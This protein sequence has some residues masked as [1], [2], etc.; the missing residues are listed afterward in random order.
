MK[1]LLFA[2]PKGR[3]LDEL[4]PLLKKI[5]II[6]EDDFFNDNSRKLVFKTN[7]ENLEIVK[8][9][10]F[11]VATFVKFGAADLGICGLDVLEEFSKENTAEKNYVSEIFPLI[12]LK[13]GKCRL[14]IAAKKSVA[15]D[16]KSRSHIR[17]ATKYTAIAQKYFSALGIQAEAV[18][19]NGS[20]EIAPQLNLCDFILDLVSSGKTL[21]ENDMVELE[22]ILDVTSYLIVNRTSFKTANQEINELISIF[23]GA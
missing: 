18:K 16:L 2:V 12:D 22:K 6:P 10:S 5:G 17:I 3:I 15:L 7:R 23:D 21:I 14:S 1:K 9:R 20:I 11:D 4:T 13:I 8:V 19:L